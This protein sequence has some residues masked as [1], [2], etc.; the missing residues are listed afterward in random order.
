MHSKKNK[1]KSSLYT[2]T[3]AGY[4]LPLRAGTSVPW[5]PAAPLPSARGREALGHLWSSAIA[6]GNND[7]QGS[8]GLQLV[9]LQMQ[10]LTQRQTFG[11]ELYFELCTCLYNPS[12]SQI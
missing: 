11:F 3:A 4:R 6:L 1:Q 8:E 7:E 5:P 10:Y 9:S 12:V 2:Q